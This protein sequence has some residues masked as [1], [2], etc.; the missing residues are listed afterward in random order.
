MQECVAETVPDTEGD[1]AFN[2]RETGWRVSDPQCRSP[3]DKSQAILTPRVPTLTAKAV[4]A[5]YTR[6]LSTVAS[7]SQPIPSLSHSTRANELDWLIHPGGALILSTLTKILALSGPSDDPT[8]TTPSWQM[9]RERGNASSASIGGVMERGRLLGGREKVVAVAFGPG[10]TVEMALL[11]RTGWRGREHAGGQE[12][13]PDGTGE[14]GS[15]QS[16]RTGEVVA[17]AKGELEVMLD[18][19]AE[20]LD[21]RAERKM[22]NGHVGSKMTN[23]HTGSTMTNGHVESERADVP[24][25]KVVGGAD[26]CVCISRPSLFG[27]SGLDCWCRS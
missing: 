9:Y 21:G 14:V 12:V 3:T 20:V 2:I 5:L 25:L 1:L 6:L 22:A 27:G 15:D 17:K 8:Q 7:R 4:P 24:R 18:G 11:R 23:G 10:L 19:R 13:V 16:E 26:R